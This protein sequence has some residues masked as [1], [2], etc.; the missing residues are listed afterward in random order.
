MKSKSVKGN[1]CQTDHKP[2]VSMADAS[3]QICDKQI[4]CDKNKQY[5]MLWKQVPLADVLQALKDS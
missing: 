4:T 5:R 2:D 1:K 3:P